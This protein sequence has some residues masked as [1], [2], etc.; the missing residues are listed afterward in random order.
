MRALVVYESMF[1]NTRDVARA[2]ADGIGTQMPVELVEVAAAPTTI[3]ADVELLVVGGPTHA[4]GLT[5]A[6]TR[7][8]AAKRAGDRLVSRGIGLDE[9]IDGLQ[10]GPASI[11]AA[12]FDT[13]IKGPELLWGS[14]AKGAK[15]RLIALRFRMIAPPESFL[16]GGPTGP[17]FDRL[18]TGELERAGAWGSS[19]AATVRP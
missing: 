16:I 19:L 18:G 4:H 8:V 3:P 12:T 1:G 5:S 9:W 13:R 6:K 11:A 2:V 14:A 7:A 17:S 15:K 10:S